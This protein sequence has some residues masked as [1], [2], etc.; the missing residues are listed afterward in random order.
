[1]Q[2]LIFFSLQLNRVAHFAAQK[3][4]SLN[5]QPKYN[6]IIQKQSQAFFESFLIFFN[7]FEKILST[8]KTPYF[9]TSFLVYT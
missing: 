5:R 9:Y 6:T 1:M 3:T 8:R 2:L 4:T 7:F